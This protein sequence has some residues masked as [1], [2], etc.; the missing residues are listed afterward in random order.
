MKTTDKTV[1][2]DL[3]AKEIWFFKKQLGIMVQILSDKYPSELKMVVSRR[4]TKFYKTIMHLFKVDLVRI[5][6]EHLGE[7]Y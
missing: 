3:W 4:T 1:I 7:K 2:I 6:G 5:Y